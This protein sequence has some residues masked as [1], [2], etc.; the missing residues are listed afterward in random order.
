M[1]T[2]TLTQRN[3]HIHTHTCKH[4]NTHIHIL[5]QQTYKHRHKYTHTLTQQTHTHTS[6]SLPLEP[7]ASHRGNI[8]LIHPEFKIGY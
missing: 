2:H 6:V 1:N 5:T 7:L 8:F 4:T 3:T